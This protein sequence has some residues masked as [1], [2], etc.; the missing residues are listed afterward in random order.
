MDL[1]E[2][3]NKIHSNLLLLE[4]IGE[5]VTIKENSCKEFG[6]HFVITAEYNGMTAKV[7]IEKTEVEAPAFRWRYYSNPNDETT[8]LVERN[9]TINGFVHDLIEVFNKKRFDSD[10]LSQITD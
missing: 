1:R 9:S 4:N 3:I 6:N 7:I 10:Y 5:T 2:N 8:G